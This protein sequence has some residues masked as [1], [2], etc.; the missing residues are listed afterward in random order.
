LAELQRTPI[1]SP[2]SARI[3]RAV[4][5]APSSFRSQ[6]A[7]L[8]PSRDSR[9]AMARPRPRAAPVTTA[10]LVKAGTGFPNFKKGELKD[11]QQWPE[12]TRRAPTD[13]LA[14]YS[15]LAA[16]FADD[17]HPR[18]IG[19]AAPVTSVLFVALSSVA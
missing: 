8:I 11:T 14:N 6:A 3:S 1:A 16:S 7:T 18:I 19:T 2:P 17:E 13:A 4:S 12:R 5:S 15:S 10:T 9:C